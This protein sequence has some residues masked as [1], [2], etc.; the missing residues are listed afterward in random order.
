MTRL[1]LGRGTNGAASVAARYLNRHGLITGATGKGKSNTVAAMVEGLSALGVP[2]LVLDVKGDLSGLA[3]STP[4]ALFDPFGQTGRR[5]PLDLWRLG[6][7]LIARALDLSEA[8]SGCLDVVFTVAE[9]RG[10]PLATLDDLR[11]A[12]GH[13]AADREAISAEYGL[14]S[15]SSLAAVQR[16]ALR[17][18]R[19]GRTAF[20]SPCVDVAA[21]MEGRTV[22]IVDASRMILTPGLYAAWTTFVLLDLFERAPEVGDLDRP[23]LAVF[24]DEAHL[25]FEGASPGLVRRLEMVAR[26]I[27]SKGVALF[28]A[29]QSPADIPPAIAGQLQNRIQHG[30]HGV[31][32]ADQRAIRA[33]ADTLPVRAGI[34]AYEAIGSLG[35]GA[36]LVSL[37][38]DDGTPGLADMVRVD[39]AR[40][41]LRPLSDGER[42]AMGVRPWIEPAKVET[43]AA[44]CQAVQAEPR[45]R[46][47]GMWW[48][49]P[50][51][52]LACLFVAL[53]IM[54]AP[55]V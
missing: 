24:L 39:R 29:T 20:G 37:V 23:R 36:A 12:L 38:T 22:S 55:P 19:S 43:V 10:L 47:R 28:L 1:T 34:R 41:D 26:L 2:S 8:Q 14:V 16:A 18:E 35:V 53:L 42:A 5:V 11:A 49:V 6:P 25:I 15:Q 21:F 46:R 40:A 52:V 27:R 54:P 32:P 50:A 13:C 17:L 7:D 4:A 45:K 44:P 48:K 31:T 30:L 9:A 3:R 51:A 33:A